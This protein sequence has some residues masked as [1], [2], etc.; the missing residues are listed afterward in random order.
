MDFVPLFS[1]N[2]QCQYII[3]MCSRTYPWPS[4]D[5]KKHGLPNVILKTKPCYAKLKSSK[6]DDFH[7]KQHENWTTNTQTNHFFQIKLNMLNKQ[8]MVCDELN[9]QIRFDPS[10]R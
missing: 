8:C 10:R 9:L 6:P 7:M 5:R 2:R 3:F 4:E 1:T